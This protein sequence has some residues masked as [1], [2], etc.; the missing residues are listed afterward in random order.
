VPV[1]KGADFRQILKD[2]TTLL[3]TPRGCGIKR[4]PIRCLSTQNT[5]IVLPQASEVL[6]DLAHQE[7]TNDGC[8]SGGF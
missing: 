5:M 7:M 4:S 8:C 6:S 3:A 2:I 1:H